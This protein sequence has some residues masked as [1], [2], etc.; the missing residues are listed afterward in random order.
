MIKGE[1]DQ[2]HSVALRK[3]LVLGYGTISVLFKFRVTLANCGMGGID[4]QVPLADV[5]LSFLPS[6]LLA[7][8][9]SLFFL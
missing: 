2:V 5:L 6:L 9:P 4:L 8:R 7:I 1:N 3:T